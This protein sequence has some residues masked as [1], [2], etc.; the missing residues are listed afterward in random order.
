M[1]V[2][3]FFVWLTEID[4]I[5][6]TSQLM[7]LNMRLFWT[8]RLFVFINFKFSEYVWVIKL[9]LHRIHFE[10]E[11]GLGRMNTKNQK[12]PMIIMLFINRP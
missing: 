10:N 3:Y 2:A 11:H 7:I 9:K 6:K 8:I 5:K 1:H 4:D 12:S